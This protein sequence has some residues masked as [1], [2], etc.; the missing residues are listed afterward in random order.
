[1]KKE[2][3]LSMTRELKFKEL[4]EKIDAEESDRI[5]KEAIKSTRSSKKD[6]PSKLEKEI[7][8]MLEVETKKTRRKRTA[9]IDNLDEEISNLLDKK[10]EDEEVKV[11]KVNIDEDLYLTSSFKPLKHRIKMSKI[12]KFFLKLIFI[13]ALI[14][15]FI[16]FIALPVYNMIEDS[17]PKAIFDHSLDYIQ[18]QINIILDD[19]IELDADKFSVEAKFGFDSNIKEYKQLVDNDFIFNIGI[20]TKNNLFETGYYVEN[21][22]KVRHGYRYIEKNNKVFTQYTTSNTIFDEGEVETDNEDTLIA[23]EDVEYLSSEDYKYYVDT[24]IKGLK[25]LI[26]PED[27]T[28]NKE[29]LDID[30]FTIDVVRNT[31]E[32]DKKSITSFEKELKNKLL[33]D[34]KFLSIAAGINS[35]TIEELKKIYKE[36]TNY[37]EDFTASISI[38]V[39]KGNKFVGFDIEEKGFRNYYFYKYD[40]KFEA[41]ANISEDKEC[42]TGGDCTSSARKVL[43]LIGTN[44]N[45]LTKVDIFLNDEDIGSLEIKNF[46]YN[47]IDLDYNLI[48]DDIKYEGNLLVVFDNKNKKYELGFSLEIVEQYL[49]FNVEIAFD[50]IKDIASFDESKVVEYTDKLFEKESTDFCNISKKEGLYDSYIIW[51]DSISTAVSKMESE[52]KTSNSDI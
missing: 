7:D 35:T 18:E 31:L 20:D 23:S 8:E 3:K 10:E 28:S 1:M 42:L 40:N 6:E 34:E 4:Q 14:G 37:D 12:I 36:E 41:H 19:N 25:D 11:S 22:K 50:T 45:N 26:K 48:V 15:A 49:S 46:S 13:I 29:E 24:L 43:H 33:G 47:K 44:K 32:F 51:I 27:L 38:Y 39:T 5:V 2:E 17:K 52:E 16:Y 21:D 9:E 30:G